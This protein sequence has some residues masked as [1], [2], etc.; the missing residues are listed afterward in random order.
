M[1]AMCGITGFLESTAHRP[2]EELRAIAGT[3][4]GTLGHRGPDDHAVWCD[5]PRGLA[6]G[7]QR[8]SILDLSEGGRQPMTSRDGRFVITYNGEIY[9]YRQMRSHLETRG[10]RFRGHSDTEVLLE[11]IACLG[12]EEALRR[13]IGMFAFAVWD[14]RNRQLT[15][16]RDR[17]GIKPLYYGWSDGVFLFAS[18]LKALRAH[19]RFQAEIDRAALALFLQ[20]NYIPAPHTI[21]RGFFKLPA[22][23]F[24]TVAP[25]SDPASAEL[26]PYWS[27]KQTVEEGLQRP[28]RGSAH[29]GVEQL[30]SLL[31][32]SVR[33]HME[34]DVPLGAF[35]SGGID[36]TAVVAVMQAQSP[37]AVRTFT[38]GFHEPP[39]DEAAYARAV[40][41]HLGTE[42]VECYVTPAEAREVIPR[43]P[44][45]YDEPFAD[46]S[47]IPTFLVSRI[48]RDHVKVSLS[49]DG[50]DEL[51]C[52]YDRYALARRVWRWIGWLPWPLRKAVSMAL[53]AVAQ[54]SS[55]GAVP[56]KVGTLARLLACRTPADLYGDLSTH[57]KGPA[58]LVIGGQL[59][60]TG[61]FRLEDWPA[62]AKLAEA[63]MYV[64]AARYLPDDILTKLDRA[65][66]AVG[67]EARVPLLDH[68]VVAFAWSLPLE[69]KVREGQTKWILRRL[70]DRYVPR[71][72]V[73]RPKV[74]FGVPID[75]WLRGPLRPWAE[76]LLSEQRLK[77][78]GFLKPKPIR[79]K[80]LEHVSCLA[81]WH[82]LLWDILMFQAWREENR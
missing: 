63:L 42:H 60:P 17:L 27:L 8:L 45:L 59:S 5:A 11:A 12:V 32:D 7:H 82:Y 76:D 80:W 50:G 33:L 6:L 15:L 49:G 78:D 29:E 77:E 4:A 56:R 61:C 73:E 3:M 13:S 35:L 74:G 72:L 41:D 70:L 38:I 53:A 25:G 22:G 43:L 39:Y 67:L 24:L 2:A 23:T 52:G 46:S 37:A 21:Y 31:K 75:T 51:F 48:T 68:R 58:D 20:H 40:A 81:D 10:V 28:F 16:A 54:G 64:D 9:N 26:V 34:A 44:T 19:P 57:W 62:G 66:M 14:C 65:S 79:E 18:E 55:A 71:A 47:Q 30:D 69:W 1:F 36:S